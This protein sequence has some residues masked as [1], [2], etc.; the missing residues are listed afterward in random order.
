MSWKWKLLSH[1]WLLVT[2]WAIQSMEFSRPEYWST[3]VLQNTGVGSLSLLQGI[4]PTQGSNPGF[5][6]CRRILHQLSHKGSQRM[7]DWVAYPFCNRSS[8]P[9]KWTDVSSIAGRIFPTELSAKSWGRPKV[10]VRG[11]CFPKVAL[12]YILISMDILPPCRENWGCIEFKKDPK[13]LRVKR[14]KHQ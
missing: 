1:F 3:G 2:P 7:L 13:T 9:R 10:D 8:L 12:V 5:P 4:F 6:H 14:E 11:P